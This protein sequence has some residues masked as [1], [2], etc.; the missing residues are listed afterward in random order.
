ME[1]FGGDGQ[2]RH[3]DY[4]GEPERDVDVEALEAQDTFFS[5]SLRVGIRPLV[6]A[7]WR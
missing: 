5:L 3:V 6:S 4:P 1:E 2:H 7:E